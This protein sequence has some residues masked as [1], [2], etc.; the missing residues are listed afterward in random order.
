M[1]HEPGTPPPAGADSRP[2]ALFLISGVLLA[3]A[4]LVGLAREQNWGQK[5]FALK[6]RTS[7][8]EGLRPGMEVRIA[9]LPVGKVK[10]LQLGDD[11][12]VE[13]ELEVQERYRHLVG[14]RSRAYQGQ[15]GF[16]GDHFV[17]ITPDTARD[18]PVRK[19]P[20]DLPYEPSPNL[21]NLLKGIETTRGTLQRTL[22]HTNVLAARDVPRTLAEMRQS[23]QT[24]SRLSGRVQKETEATAPEIRRTLR[25]VDQTAA[26]ARR[27]ADTA[28][29]TAI[30]ARRAADEASQT[31]GSSRPLLLRILRDVQ[32]ITAVAKGLLHTLLGSEALGGPDGKAPRPEAPGDAPRALP[33]RP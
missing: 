20:V 30:S 18:L 9:G 3:I 8:A 28:T 15:D 1:T 14:P 16:V 31:L 5:L 26:T 21:R 25:Q 13:I 22:D 27:T 32:G 12:K 4:L 23:L 24:L 10:N 33:E 17:V 7:D 2:S 29:S 19:T 6:V 11:A